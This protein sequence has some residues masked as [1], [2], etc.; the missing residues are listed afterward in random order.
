LSYDKVQICEEV[1]GIYFGIMPQL[2]VGLCEAQ[3]NTT[4]YPISLTKIE[5]PSTK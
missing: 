1:S 4:N 5:V 3:I 2:E